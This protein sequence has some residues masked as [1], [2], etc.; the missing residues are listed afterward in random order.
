MNRLLAL[1]LLMVAGCDQP[2]PFTP[3]CS[4][5]DEAR[6]Y[7]CV[8]QYYWRVFQVD[9]DERVDAHADFGAVLDEHAPGDPALSFERANVYFRRGQLAMAIAIEE[10]VGDDQI[11][12]VAS[13]VPDFEQT[14]RLAPDYSIVVSWKASMEIAIAHVTG[15]DAR[16]TE[17]YDAAER[18]IRE[19]PLGNVPSISGTAIGLPLS[20]GVPQRVIEAIDE[21]ECEGPEFCERNT[22]HAPW[23]RPGMAY[24]WAEH[25]ARVG[26]RET[27]VRYLDES[28]RAEGFDAWPYRWVVEEAAADP[29]ALLA[30]FAERGE[31]G[32][33]FDIMYAN[34]EYGC[35][36]CHAP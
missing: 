2:E 18:E 26:D 21:W 11:R 22:E 14:E 31:D 29:D 15:D 1:A 20:T 3:D 17:L 9:R 34:A 33:C 5:L 16:A 28:L 30:R 6:A 10:N 25:Y 36:F 8:E 13:I 23:A 24:H 4:G 19:D 27:T 12:F 7:E 35:V 32:S